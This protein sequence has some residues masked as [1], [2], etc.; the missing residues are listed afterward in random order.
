MLERGLGV[1]EILVVTYT[2]AATAGSAIASGRRSP[3]CAKRSGR[4]APPTS[5]C[6]RLARLADRPAA[7]AI[8]DRALTGFDEAAIFTIHGFCQPRALRQRAFE[9]GVA[10]DLE[11]VPDRREL[12][13]EAHR[14]FWRRR[15]HGARPTFVR[16]V[17][18]KAAHAQCWPD[19][20]RTTPAGRIGAS[21]RRTT[22]WTIATLEGAFEARRA[23]LR[24]A[25]ARDGASAA[26]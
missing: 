9:S 19:W 26:R 14:R 1:R 25:W 18:A 2:K 13:Q 23:E 17:L 12:A 21:T 22:A 16:H 6:E 4:G 15:L 20:C 10:F 7:L 24:D 8:V 11:L 5:S 3:P